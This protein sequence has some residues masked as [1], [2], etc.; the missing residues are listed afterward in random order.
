MDVLRF[1]PRGSMLAAALDLRLV[2]VTRSQVC[3][4]SALW[5]VAACC[6]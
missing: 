5:C 3:G 1:E 2:G 4:C 6:I